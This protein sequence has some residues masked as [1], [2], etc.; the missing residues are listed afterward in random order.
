MLNF[1]AVLEVTEPGYMQEVSKVY[2]DRI[3][4][5]ED[6]GYEVTKHKT[7]KYTVFT[8]EKDGKRVCFVNHSANEITVDG[9]DE[10]GDEIFSQMPEG[11][12]VDFVV[13][14]MGN[15][16]STA[17]LSRTMKEHYPDV[18]V[19]GLEDER[20]PYYFDQKYP[21]QYERIFGKPLV[22]SLHDM[23]GSSA[24]GVRLKY[25]NVDYV[26]EVRLSNPKDRDDA[27]DKYNRGRK[28]FERIGNSSAASLAVARQ[29]AIEHPG[30]KIVVV[31]YDKADQY[32]DSPAIDTNIMFNF[33]RTRAE[34]IP[35]ISGRVQPRL[36]S[37]ALMPRSIEESIKASN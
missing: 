9:F 3:A 20:S 10:I 11:E 25:G 32:G 22:Y 33:A 4:Q 5:L 30:S 27:R 37:I 13:S 36:G 35:R 7:P 26:D 18:K 19:V 1:G 31:F 24:P 29:L 12:Q 17:A 16:T 2:V 14:V 6:E 21:G 28:G 15:G 23:F 34:G 8:A